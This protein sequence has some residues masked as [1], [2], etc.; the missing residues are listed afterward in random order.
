MGRQAEFIFLALVICALTLSS[1]LQPRGPPNLPAV[2]TPSVPLPPEPAQPPLASNGKLVTSLAAEGGQQKRLRV[3][4]IMLVLNIFPVWWPFLVASYRLNHPS[5]ELLVVHA[6][7]SRPE[8][9]AGAEHVQYAELSVAELVEL[10]ARKLDVAPARVTA[11]FAS[12]K[13]LSDLK[14]FYGRRAWPPTLPPDSRLPNG[15]CVTLCNRGCVALCSRGCNP[16]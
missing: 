6:N 15:G 14:P 4:L 16:V 3:R 11:K 9:S 5:I 2:V 7:V 1:L 8:P 10:F 12:V 13:G